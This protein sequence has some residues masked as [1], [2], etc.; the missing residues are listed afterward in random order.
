MTS[1]WTI[2][3][4]ALSL[5]VLLLAVL[6][7]GTLR[8][9]AVVLERAQAELPAASDRSMTLGISPGSTIPY[10]TAEEVGRGAFTSDDLLGSPA[11]VL[12]LG[13]SCAPCRDLIDDLRAGHVPETAAR[14][15]VVVDASDAAELAV[16]SH[17]TVLAERDKEVARAFETTATPHGFAVSPDGVVSA[18]GH[19]NDWEAV[20]RLAAEFN[21]GGA[22]QTDTI[23]AVTG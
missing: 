14:L 11:V 21:Q 18:V 20:A 15:V 5:L 17:V 9:I 23:S 7:V 10:F 4:L 12:F 6:V 2:A 1:A 8:R 13:T 3:F 22:P 19:P 16:S